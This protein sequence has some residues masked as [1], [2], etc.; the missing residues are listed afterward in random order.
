MMLTRRV[1]ARLDRLRLRV[2][3]EQINGV[4][5]INVVNAE[6]VAS[7]YEDVRAALVVESGGRSALH[8]RHLRE[9]SLNFR[10]FDIACETVLLDITN[11]KFSFRNY[12]LIDDKLNAIFSDT[13]AEDEVLG[14]LRYA[15]RHCRRV[16][17]SIA[18]LSN[19]WVDNYYHWMQ[20]T[21]PLLRFYRTMTRNQ[22]IDFYYLGESRMR[23]IQEETLL[24][25]G[26]RPHQLLREPC[27][28]DRLLTAISL[29]RPQH[30]GLRYRD[31]WGHQFVRS[32]YPIEPDRT[33]PARIYVL[34]GKT[35]TRKLTNEAEVIK[36]L[37]KFDFVPVG[38]DGLTCEAQARLFANAEAIIGVH[39]AALT[40]LLFANDGCKVIEMFPSEAPEAS[41]FTAA[42]YAKAEYYY[43][44]G[45]G[46][47]PRSTSDFTVDLHKLSRLL[48]MA[49]IA[50]RN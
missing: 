43:F 33:S 19:T 5:S 39:G 21:L 3:G 27:R 31:M 50:G 14:F 49:A 25:L 38:M 8:A 13:F 7:R 18:Y 30:A 40:N 36:L 37:E 6:A 47:G 44:L 29:H 48:K 17:G 9:D 28:G 34:R 2:L 42:T 12:L 26:V 45:E 22:K 15:P 11:P 32:I 46:S 16:R 1:A 24:R 10:P 41:F 35:R 20:L 4:I 23:R